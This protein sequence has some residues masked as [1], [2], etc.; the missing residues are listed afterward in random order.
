M[1]YVTAVDQVREALSKMDL[2]GRT[3]VLTPKEAGRKSVPVLSQVIEEACY[4][5]LGEEQDK[6]IKVS[7]EIKQLCKEIS[8]C[9]EMKA[10]YEFIDNVL[11]AEE[12]DNKTMD[13]L[14]KLEEMFNK[15]KDK[16]VNEL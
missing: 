16:N 13:K 12:I 5:V 14:N 9:K 3:I 7:E 2:S 6:K 10:A 8:K 4:K 1:K 15:I 11:G